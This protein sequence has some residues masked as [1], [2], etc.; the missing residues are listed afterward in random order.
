MRTGDPAP[1]GN[2]FFAS[3]GLSVGGLNDAGQ[4]VFVAELVGTSNGTGDNAGIF[5]G[6]G[7]ARWIAPSISTTPAK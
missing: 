2:G 4:G 7:R 1:D 3:S 5:R 6:D